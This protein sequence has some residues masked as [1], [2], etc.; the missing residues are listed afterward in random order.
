MVIVSPMWR[1][2]SY[3]FSWYSLVK[4]LTQISYWLLLHSVYGKF[5][6]H[7]RQMQ[8]VPQCSIYSSV[9]LSVAASLCFS[10]QCPAWYHS[11]GVFL[12]AVPGMVGGM[13]RA[14]VPRYTVQQPK[15]ANMLGQPGP[16]LQQQQQQQPQLQ[17]QPPQQQQ[18]QQQPRMQQ[19]QHPVRSMVTCLAGDAHRIFC[20]YR[21]LPLVFLFV[22]LRLT[23][24]VMN[25]S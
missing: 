24:N 21:C 7:E 2:R 4:P 9:R 23:F 3:C 20:R 5:S 13:M 1:I 15:Q 25:C 22:G 19:P 18:Q 11:L 8:S 14:Q 6:P 16:G 17:Q 10:L 12:S